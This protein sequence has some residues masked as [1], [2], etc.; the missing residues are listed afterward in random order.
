MIRPPASAT[1]GDVARDWRALLDA[2]AAPAA[3]TPLAL[4]LEVRVRDARGANPWA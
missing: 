4:R 3:A 2:G 1:P